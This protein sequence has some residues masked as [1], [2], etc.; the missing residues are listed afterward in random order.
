NSIMK[1]RKLQIAVVGSAARSEYRGRGGASSFMLK[2]AEKVG[3]LLARE[4]AVVVTGG[5]GGIMEAAARGA[6]K[7]G[8]VTVGVVKGKLRTISNRFTDIEVLTGMEADGL[9]ELILVL[10]SDAVIV[11]G[12]GAGTLQE[13]ALA[14]RN[15]K[16]IVVLDGMSGWGARL[17]GQFVDERQLVKLIKARTP[18]EAVRRAYGLAK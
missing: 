7:G 13:I 9:D 15:K 10:M 14:Y 18:E 5:K 3:F 2:A 4:G 1:R 12:G 17:A 8:G 6:K 11:L 16:P